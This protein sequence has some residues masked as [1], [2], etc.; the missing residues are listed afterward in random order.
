MGYRLWWRIILAGFGGIGWLIPAATLAQ[1]MIL[2]SSTDFFR[3]ASPNP[4]G[5]LNQ[6]QPYPT[7]PNWTPTPPPKRPPVTNPEG[8]V[9]ANGAGAASDFPEIDPAL[10][11]AIRQGGRGTLTPQGY[12]I[13]PGGENFTFKVGPVNFRVGAGLRTEFIDNVFD[14]A[15]NRQSDL[16]VAPSIYL[17]G[18]WKISP[19]NDVIVN[20]GFGYTA[21]LEHS[22]L[23]SVTRNIDIAPGSDLAFKVRIGDVSLRLYERPSL[24]Q[25]SSYQLTLPNDV[26]YYTFTNH[27]GLSLFGDFNAL[28]IQATLD[29]TDSIPLGSTAASAN[30]SANASVN[31]SANAAAVGTL[32]HSIDTLSSSATYRLSDTNSIGLEGSVSIIK[33]KEDFQNNGVSYRLGVFVGSQLSE[34]I[35]LRVSGGYQIMNFNTGGLNQ[36]TSSNSAS[37]YGLLALTHHVN[38]YL[39]HTLSITHEADLGSTTN[40]VDMTDIAEQAVWKISPNLSLNIGGF[41]EFGTESGPFGQSIRLFGL[42]ASTGWNLS[43]KLSVNVYYQLT[44]R[45]GGGS[46]TGAPSNGSTLGTGSAGSYYE[47]RVGVNFTYAF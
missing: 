35:S 12:P 13:V 21:Y 18:H 7:L 14:T 38:R 1:D 45:A 42:T 34:Y 36:D 5:P 9:P 2:P 47:N 17:I 22:A 40:S 23:S 3:S 46:G 27:L 30:G 44:D 37:P 4:L 16:I 11:A 10:A 20:L 6:P 43:R 28:Q 19:M 15:T 32:E 29:R 33:Y 39:S 41:Y 24:G 8:T 26:F 31:T 25:D